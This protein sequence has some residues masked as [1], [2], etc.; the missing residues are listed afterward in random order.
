MLP[1]SNET[2][3]VVRIKYVKNIELYVGGEWINVSVNM[4][5]KR[6]FTQAVTRLNGN[7]VMVTHW[8]V[9]GKSK[10]SIGIFK[11]ED[12]VKAMYVIDSYKVQD[13]A[14]TA[15]EYLYR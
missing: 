6:D 8:N 11:N 5:V 9:N 14:E 7:K 10:W 13:A 4:P 1:L 3:I 2:E 15:A 12:D